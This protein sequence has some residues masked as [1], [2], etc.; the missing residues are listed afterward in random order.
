I[1]ALTTRTAD[2]WANI[3]LSG[4][5]DEFISEGRGGKHIPSFYDV[6]PD[7]ELS[8]KTYSI[9]RC[10]AKAADFD[11]SE[12]AKFI[13]EQFYTITDVKKD[14]NDS[15]IRSMQS[16]RID[17]RRWGARFESNSQRPYFEGHER[18][19]VVQHRTEFLQHFLPKKDSYYLISEGAQPKWQTPKVNVPTVLIFHDESTFRSGEVSAKRWLY[20]DQAPFYSKG[21]GRSNMLSDFLVMHPSGPFFQLSST[22]YDKALEKY[23]ELDEEQD[24]DYIE[25]SASA[26]VHLSSDAYFD[27]STILAQFERLLKLLQFKECFN[28][29]SIEIVV[30][31]ARTHSAR[32][33]NLLEFGKGVSTRCPVDQL[34]WVDDK[35]I[36]QSLPC[37][38]QRGPNRGKSKGLLQI[39]I[40]L[41]CNPS[42][43]AKLSELRQLLAHHPAFRNISRLEQLA[44]KY[45]V[46]LLFCPKYHCEINSIEGCWAHMKQFI[47]KRTDQKYP[48]MIRLYSHHDMTD[49]D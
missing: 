16:C 13:D 24:V 7:I 37:Y 43:K 28:N 17:L 36:T 6:F 18:Q 46:F 47:R 15:L 23:P 35:G 25:R 2:K 31:N 9:Q 29:H 48:T 39:A 38:F 14:P 4:S 27:N 20:N 19:D 30:D 33:Y 8:A 49:I 5:F 44:Q 41:N 11:V 21:R 22:E 45:G 26:S 12:L 32:A 10:A 3:F 40:E 42:L 34:Q 1:G